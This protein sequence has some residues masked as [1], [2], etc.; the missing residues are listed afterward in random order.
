MIPYSGK[1]GMNVPES[2]EDFLMTQSPT[3][4][5]PLLGQTV[6]IVEDSRFASEALRLICQRSGARIRR[7]DSLASAAR[8]LRMYRPGVVLVDVG[9]P[10]GSGLDLIAS[11]S[12]SDR[13]IE[14]VIAMSGDDDFAPAQALAAGAQDFIAKPITSISSFQEL[15]LSHLPASARPVEIRASGVDEVVPDVIGLQDDFA[16]AAELLGPKPDPQLIDYVAGFLGGVARSARDDDLV[17]A[18]GALSTAR[19]A[20]VETL[21]RQI[22]TLRDLLEARLRDIPTL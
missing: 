3:A 8:H 1:E 5:R 16:H 18:V 12:R 11:L 22:E 6:L 10:D 14:C 15:I 20:G 4:E 19:D 13:P 7:A 2:L 9:L 17:D 21:N